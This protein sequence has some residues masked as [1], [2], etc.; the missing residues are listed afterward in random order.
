MTGPTRDVQE[1]ETVKTAPSNAPI[2]EQL[3]SDEDWAQ[4]SSKF[5]DPQ[6]P[7]SLPWLRLLQVLHQNKAKSC[8]IEPHYVCLDWRSEVSAFH[9]NLDVTRRSYTQ[10]LHFFTDDLQPEDCYNL[11]ESGGSYLGYV[12]LRDRDL[13]IVGRAL[14]VP[15][16]VLRGSDYRLTEVTDEV[17]FYGQILRVSGVPFM[18]Q[19]EHF[20]HCAHVVTWMAHYSAFCRGICERKLISDFVKSR[21][22]LVPMPYLNGIYACGPRCRAAGHLLFPGRPSQRHQERRQGFSSGG[23]GWRLCLRRETR[24]Q[25][26]Q[27]S[28]TAPGWTG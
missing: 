3:D 21:T 16:P 15:P 24:R 8:V 23:S 26:H 10:R 9:S 1:P 19:D 27:R 7:Q 25:V 14:V 5:V 18:Q 2:V 17:H 13:P 6:A 22:D 20:A 4:F 12:V 11:G 28:Y